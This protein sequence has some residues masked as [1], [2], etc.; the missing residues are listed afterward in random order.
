[1]KEEIAKYICTTLL[2]IIGFFIVKSYNNV[3][4]Q[5]AKLQDDVVGLKIA[6]IEIQKSTL[7]EARVKEIVDLELI[8]HGLIKR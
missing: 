5:L 4:L 2:G 6:L 8:K 7:D 1:M 3:A